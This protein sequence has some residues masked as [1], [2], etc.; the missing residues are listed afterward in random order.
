MTHAEYPI[1]EVQG[2]YRTV[3]ELRQHVASADL[4]RADAMERMTQQDQTIDALKA[5]VAELDATLR[6][7]K[8]HAHALSAAIIN[9]MAERSPDDIGRDYTGHINLMGALG[10]PDYMRGPLSCR[11]VDTRSTKPR[12]A[13][14]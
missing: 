5:R 9:G 11:H 10:Y 8:D 14:A 7:A 2:L 3:A 6:T 12:K 4:Y 13:K 1:A